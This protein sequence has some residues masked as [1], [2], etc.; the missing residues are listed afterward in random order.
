M[1]RHMPGMGA[2]TNSP[3]RAP[4]QC[5]PGALAPRCACLRDLP[6]AHFRH[7]F[8]QVVEAGTLLPGSV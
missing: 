6:V 2:Q 1:N 8:S 7:P 4:E 5:G 3:F